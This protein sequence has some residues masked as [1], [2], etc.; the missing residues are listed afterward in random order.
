MTT[1]TVG[2]AGA[3]TAA[4]DR[5]ALAALVTEL[6]N[7]PMS[8]FRTL[9][10]P[11]AEALR[12]A[13]ELGDTDLAHRAR[14]L[15]AGVLLRQGRTEEGGPIAHR[16]L[17]WAEQHGT[18]YLLARVHRELSVFYRQVG[19]VSDALTHAVQGVAHLTDDVPAAI[20]ARHV[21][22]LAVALDENGSTAEGDRRFREALDVAT[23]LGDDEVTLNILNNM[24]YTA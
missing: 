1:D 3:A 5:A 2:T 6:E 20:R 18:P 7:R 4:T 16:V 23:A 17:A 11:A 12:R 22:S 9:P 14:L 24:A 19:D 10:G 15:Q 8:Q 21:L 13:E